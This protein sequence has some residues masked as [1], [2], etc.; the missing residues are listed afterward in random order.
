MKRTSVLSGCAA[1]LVLMAL[2]QVHAQTADPSSA[3][4]ST[5]TATAAHEVLGP[6]LMPVPQ[7]GMSI[8]D[9]WRYG[10]WI[11]WVLA[12]GSVTGLALTLYLFWTLRAS[13]IAPASLLSELMLYVRSG[14]LATARRTCEL[15]SSPLSRIALAAFD[16]MRHTSV[17]QPALLRADVE[18][19][20]MRQAEAIQGETQL[21]LDLSVIAPM[22][23]LLGTVM[24][25]L[26][27]FGSVA[28]DVASA[29]P[30]VLAAGV[31]QAIVTTIFGLLVAIP[32]MVAYAYFRRRAARQIAAL[33]A[34]AT[35][36]VTVMT[37]RFER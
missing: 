27:A 6:V 34:S 9:A 16:H 37:S 20:G 28:T 21:L 3:E 31:S 2:P 29:K 14:D 18:A 36:L 35:A 10:G 24:G 15:R 25:M 8:R 13:Q 23:G 4:G 1:L 32:S 22:L 26:K 19:E 17:S 11:M 7:S 12:G 33:E 5:A 30:V